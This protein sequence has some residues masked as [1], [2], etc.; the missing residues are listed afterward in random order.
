MPPG[1]DRPTIKDR[2]HLAA[3]VEWSDDAIF[4]K[5]LDGV[6]LSWNR[7]AERMYGYTAAEM[8]GRSVE[9][10]VPD[11]LQGDV[12]RIMERIRGG[13]TVDHYQTRRR[14]KDGEVLH[15]SV[16]VSPIRDEAGQVIAAST[17]ARDIGDRMR[18]GSRSGSTRDGWRR[19]TRSSCA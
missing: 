13:E 9:T 18:A 14:R 8:V 3:I 6:V 12:D 10:L 17:I 7:G 19:P 2:L 11:D 16:T 15:V 5:D 4:S 1:T